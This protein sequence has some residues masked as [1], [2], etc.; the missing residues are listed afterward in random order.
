MNV[1]EI[2][3]PHNVKLSRDTEMPV[4]SC[5]LLLISWVFTIRTLEL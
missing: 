5:S 1:M 4:V 2:V 3:K